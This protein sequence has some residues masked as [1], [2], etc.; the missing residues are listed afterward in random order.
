MVSDTF[1]ER[2]LV[3]SARAVDASR[4]TRDTDLPWDLFRLV[5]NRRPIAG[6]GRPVPDALFLPPVLGTSLQGVP[7]EEVLFL[8]DE[9]ANM[10]WAVERIVESPLGRPLNRS[11]AYVT[12]RRQ[13][14]GTVAS[15]AATGAAPGPLVY[16]LA[17][18]IPEHWVPLLPMRLRANAPPIGLQRGARWQGRIL[19][20][21]RDAEG[22]ALPLQEEEVSREGARV[23]RAFQYARWID[24]QTYL[25]IGRRK[26]IG[27]GEGS[28]GLH[29]D[30]LAPADQTREVAWCRSGSAESLPAPARRGACRAARVAGLA[31][32]NGGPLWGTRP[33]TCRMGRAEDIRGVES[34]AATG[35]GT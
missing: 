12:A 2:T 10:A 1:G 13:Q 19:E 27:R 21:G 34:G 17:T 15:Q 20:P 18:A 24:G 32:C 22:K 8:R 6:S 11:E 28:S 14:V 7:L 25:W 31:R 29:F 5:R 35:R 23:T 4:T 30:I 3:S 9:I 26:G 33:Q 16:R